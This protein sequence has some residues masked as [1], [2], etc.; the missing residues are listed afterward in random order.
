MGSRALSGIK[1]RSI[2]RPKSHATCVTSQ[3]TVRNSPI[4]DGKCTWAFVTSPETQWMR[5]LAWLPQNPTSGRFN[6]NHQAV[7]VRVCIGL[8]ISPCCDTV[9]WK[10]YV[11]HRT[12][13]H[14]CNNTCSCSSI[15]D[16]VTLMVDGWMDGWMHTPCTTLLFACV[17]SALLMASISPRGQIAEH[18]RER[19]RGG[20]RRQ[21]QMFP[22]YGS[23][24]AVEVCASLR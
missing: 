20:G 6:G 10:A 11:K 3:S 23:L 13:E 2:P 12:W 7:I 14:D 24:T 19:E 18:A 16:E 15:A 21:G 22:C 8:P 17:I 1:R 4:S 5:G 9:K